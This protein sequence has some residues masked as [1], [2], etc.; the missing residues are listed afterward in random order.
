[1]TETFFF[2]NMKGIPSN[3]RNID[4]PQNYPIIFYISVFFLYL[5]KLLKVIEIIFEHVYK[6]SS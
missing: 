6:I 4:K 3:F 2:Y 1:M 5:Q